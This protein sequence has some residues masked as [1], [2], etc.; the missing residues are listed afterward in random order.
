MV[1]QASRDYIATDS[2]DVSDTSTKPKGKLGKCLRICK[3]VLMITAPATYYSL[4]KTCEEIKGGKAYCN[5]HSSLLMDAGAFIL[6]SKILGTEQ[7]NLRLETLNLGCCRIGPDGIFSLVIGLKH[8]KSL[9]ELIL[10]GMQVKRK[11]KK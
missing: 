6:G 7:E 3:D 10:G 8:C 11:Q 4:M 1:S 2:E 9:R 5:M